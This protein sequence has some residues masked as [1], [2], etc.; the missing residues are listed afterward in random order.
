M[1]EVA[2]KIQPAASPRQCFADRGV[3]FNTREA[4]HSDTY[5][6][7]T[8]DLPEACTL[9]QQAMAQHGALLIQCWGGCNRAPSLAVAL[10]MLE[11]ELDVV[12]AAAHVM[13]RRG[14]ILTNRTFRRRL[15][16]LAYEENRL[17]QCLE[18]VDTPLPI[19]SVYR[20]D[21]SSVEEL[22][23]LAYLATRA[24]Y[25][26]SFYDGDRRS[27]QAYIADAHVSRQSEQ[28]QWLHQRHRLLS[29]LLGWP[30]GR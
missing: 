22:L 3:I 17:L 29:S 2:R 14:A 28:V 21:T 27:L 9:A 6:V 18:T 23:I 25:Y 19:A 15:V 5:D 26:A 30:D 12:Q 10:L 8:E 13:A 4:D 20:W 16:T 11:T 24:R 1:A 7:L